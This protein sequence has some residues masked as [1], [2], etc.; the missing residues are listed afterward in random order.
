LTQQ[1]FLK[2]NQS[3]DSFQNKSSL[4]TWLYSI[5]TNTIINE[6]KRSY[7]TKELLAD[8]KT[9]CSRFMTPDFTKEVDFKIDL[10]TSLNK[11]DR[12]DQEI[13]TLRYVADYSFRDIAK[14]LKMNESSLKNRMYRFLAK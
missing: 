3:L 12:I 4:Y 13:L 2:P 10:G 14:L 8:W 7:H 9:G 1:V 6:A 5:A 11:L